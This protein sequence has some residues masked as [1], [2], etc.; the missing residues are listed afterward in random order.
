M[1]YFFLL[2]QPLV[3]NWMKLALFAGLSGVASASVLAVINQATVAGS[4]GGGGGLIV[5]LLAVLIYSLSHRALMISAASL[6]ESTVDRLRVTLEEQLRSADLRRVEKLDQNRIFATISGEMQ[7]LSDGTVNLAIVG[8][9]LLLVIMTAIY[10]LFLSVAAVI[11]AVAFSAIAAYIHLRRSKETAETLTQA[12]RLDSHLLHGFSDLIAGFKEAKLNTPR[13]QDLGRAIQDSSA[14]VA[15]VRLRTRS[16]IATDLVLSQSAFYLLI[17]L[18]AF[19]VPM[20]FTI[21]R[22][23]LVMITSGT[24]FLIGPIGLLVA[25][26]PILQRVESAAQTILGVMQEL[27]VAPEKARTF[28]PVGLPEDGFV[29]LSQVSFTYDRGDD[30]NFAVGPIDLEIRKGQMV[31]ITGSNGSGKS[32]LLKLVTGLYLPTAGVTTAKVE[33]DKVRKEIQ[34][35]GG[36]NVAKGELETYQNLFSAVFSD[37]HLFKRLYGIRSI[38]QEEAKK[39]LELVELQDKVRIVGGEF[40][41]INLSSGQR[42]RL[43]MVT[44]LLENRP[45]CVFDEWA[46]D[47]DKH[48]RDKFYF[49]ILPLLLNEYK[50]T[51]IVVSHDLEYFKSDKIPAHERYHMELHIDAANHTSALLR[52]LDPGEDPFLV[53]DPRASPSPGEAAPP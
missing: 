4:E 12:F 9:S 47:Q 32:T 10:L 18:M 31:L 51:L 36:G 15:S 35:T 7:A 16:H 29:K 52:K 41:T 3:A 42:K 17:G 23:T 2:R 1:N 11:A 19:V 45:I 34:T 20:F 39:W 46:A 21:D 48:F 38:N 30:G 5:L 8:H 14:E 26:I 40:D 24:L 6:A 37:Y 44:L 13:S 53:L 43:A 28:Q 22:Q 25:G 49:T 33:V 27:P 50:K